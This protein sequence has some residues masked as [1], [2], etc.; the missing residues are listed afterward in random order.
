[1]E[2]ENSRLS[3]KELL[4]DKS[5]ETLDE[6]LHEEL[7]QSEEGNSVWLV[8]KKAFPLIVSGFG[9]SF[10]PT[11]TFAFINSYCPDNTIFA[12][13]GLG[14]ML[15]NIFLRSYIT[16]FNNFM[17]TQVSQAFGAK[18]YYQCGE[19]LNRSKVI[20]TF[21]MFPLMVPLF[22]IGDLLVMMGQDPELSY[23]TE[24]FVRIAMPGFISQLHYDIYRKYLNSIGQFWSNMPIPVITLGTH[25]FFCWLFFKYYE[26]GLVGAGLV[27]LLQPIS[28]HLLIYLV[29]YYGEGGQYLHGLTKKAFVGWVEIIREGIPSYFLQ[30]VT[31]IS[32]ETLILLTGLIS[33]KLVVA[34]TAYINIFFLLYISIVGVQQS[35][36][37]MIG[38][39]IGAG[40]YDGALKIIKAN[41]IFGLVFGLFVVGLIL[42]F[43]DFVIRLYV[44]DEEIVQLMKD[45]LP[46]FCSTLYLT[47]YKDIL[48]GVL[49]GLGLQN[50]TLNYTIISF[51]TIYMPCIYTLMFVLEMPGSGPWISLTIVLASS[52]A[53]YHYLI[54]R[55]DII[56]K[57]QEASEMTSNYE[58]LSHTERRV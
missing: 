51:F 57:L 19:I 9:N 31:T 43:S 12:A 37:P 7:D 46:F 39:K 14:I 28:N 1:M 48:I 16:G 5:N 44:S 29:V 56:N 10:K 52:V 8:C 24:F 15:M 13:V 23:T 25:T 49:I 27:T 45:M 42:N 18:D 33:I 40:D 2:K 32:L 20:C 36:G 3:L 6:T 4:L 11:I 50:Q 34:N 47:I 38:N 35:S 26:F 53:Y 21:C 22:F 30:F 55:Y 58:T 41:I 17:I 54:N